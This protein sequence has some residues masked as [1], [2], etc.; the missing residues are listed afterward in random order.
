MS[1]TELFTKNWDIIQQNWPILASALKLH[2]IDQLDAQLVTGQN[3]TISVNGIQLSS[4]HNRLAEAE[5]LINNTQL[6][7]QKV[8]IYG[9]GMGDV[10]SLLVSDLTVK[11]IEINI[12]NLPLFALLLTYTDQSE[13]LSDNRVTI[14]HNPSQDNIDDLAIII[15]PELILA[16]DENASLRDF[17]AIEKNREY[18]NKQHKIDDPKRLQ[19]FK[20]NQCLLEQDPDAATLKLNQNQAKAYVIGAGPSLE[21][22]YAFLKAQRELPV[23]ERPL[24]IA[25]DTAFKALINEDI[26]P[27]IVISI[28]SNITRMH[29]P[30][31]IPKSVKLVYFPRVPNDVLLSWPGERFNAYSKSLMYDELDRHTPKLRLF[32]NGSVIHPAIDLAIYLQTKEL[33]LFGC[34]FSYPNN[35]TH[36]FWED[37][38]LGPK[39]A[40]AKHWVINGNGERVLTDLNFKTYLRSLEGY[41]R[42]K[43][44]TK[45][46]QSSIEGARIHGAQYKECKL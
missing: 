27:D 8:T 18:A 44:Q 26:I 5:L 4:R 30:D 22:H 25:V 23:E 7:K 16:S 17:L 20:D 36:A 40:D 35:K 21:Q 13:W 33:T 3:Q 38:A 2:K 42:S 24:M 12:L 9:V 19:R 15:T 37:G 41:V 46:Y 39:V 28:E 34:D 14:V 43:P 10:P 31:D 32:T 1:M 29:F 45:F 11:Q 6:D